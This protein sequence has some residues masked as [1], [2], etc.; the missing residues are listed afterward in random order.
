MSSLFF[1]KSGAPKRGLPGSGAGVVAHKTAQLVF[2]GQI[3]RKGFAAQNGVQFGHCG[4]VI[5]L[6]KK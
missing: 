6:K 3:Q 5:G 1:K 2:I 4:L